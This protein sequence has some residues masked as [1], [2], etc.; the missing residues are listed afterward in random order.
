MAAAWGVEQMDAGMQV[1][2]KNKQRAKYAAR[3]K[4]FDHLD[5]PFPF[6][7]HEHR[8]RALRPDHSGQGLR[9]REKRHRRYLGVASS[10]G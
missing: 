5:V 7:I 4:L 6:E 9:L 3:M 10:S 1:R 8:G 2:I